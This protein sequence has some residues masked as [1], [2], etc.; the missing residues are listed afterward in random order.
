MDTSDTIKQMQDIASLLRDK[1]DTIYDLWMEQQS[2]AGSLRLDL[3]SQED[4]EQESS[5]F[6]DVFLAALRTGNT[7]DINHDEYEP[8]RA[9]L[10]DIS[11]SRAQQGFSPS[12]TATF[13]F[14]LKDACMQIL[15]H[16]FENDGQVLRVAL[17][18]IS[19]VVD[20]L[21]LLTFETFTKTREALA[22]EQADAILSMAT[23]VTTIWDHILLLP[24][25]GTIDSARAQDIMET[26]L[27]RIQTSE[28]QV[29]ILDILGVATVDSAVAQHLIKISKATQI[30]GCQ[31]VI[32]GISP[33]IAQSLVHLGIDLGD[34]T[35]SST[36]KNGL[37]YAFAQC[38]IQTSRRQHE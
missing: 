12:E 37:A 23:P 16:S 38:N 27:S 21:G 30:M 5:E 25:I 34:I 11:S 24:V 33:H 8:V 6:I 13:I 3:M 31:C 20:K 28:A 17:T 36:L 2:S 22:L 29:I 32:T 19:Q 10:L 4:L 18:G 7:N 14:S 1:R 9:M 26:M 15:S 35:T